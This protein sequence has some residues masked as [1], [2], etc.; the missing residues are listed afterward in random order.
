[1]DVYNDFAIID[2]F[3]FDKWSCEYYASST[4]VL[5]T[6]DAPLH[7]AVLLQTPHT[8]NWSDYPKVVLHGHAFETVEEANK[9]RYPISTEETLFS[10]PADTQAL[11][12]LLS[13]HAFPEHEIFVR[14]GHGFV[15]LAPSLEK[16]RNIFEVKMKPKLREVKNVE[17]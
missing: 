2:S 1:M 11:V 17:S 15:L 3:D 8:M 16:A 5:P 13:E 7:C 4:D 14:K 12:S 9:C 10:T 6:S